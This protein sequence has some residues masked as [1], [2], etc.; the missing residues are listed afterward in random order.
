MIYP[1]KYFRFKMTRFPFY[2]LLFY[3]FSA[4]YS[5]PS[6]SI[7]IY[8]RGGIESISDSNIIPLSLNENQ[9]YSLDLNQI[10]DNKISSFCFLEKKI[11]A[12][13]GIARVGLIQKNLSS[14]TEI[15]FR[16]EDYKKDG[17]ALELN[18]VYSIRYG[19]PRIPFIA[20]LRIENISPKSLNLLCYKVPH[21]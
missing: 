14:I 4:F 16:D 9:G 3:C 5:C 10:T 2:L 17:L 21:E 6:P 12:S 18:C 15:P 8:E 7:N 20:L 19:N 11:W 13:L 1:D